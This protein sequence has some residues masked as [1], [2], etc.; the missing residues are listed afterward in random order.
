MGADAEA[1][2][3]PA[4]APAAT[5][6]LLREGPGGLE[7]YL[8]RRSRGSGFMAGNWVFPGGMV[9]AGD[10]RAELVRRA[11]DLAPEELALR[12]GDGLEASEAGAYAVAAVREA[13]EE[14]GALFLEAAGAA[15]EE[16]ARLC[17][18]RRAGRLERGWLAGLLAAGGWVLRLSALHAWSHWITPLGM[19]KRFDTRFFAALL[20]AGQACAPDGREVTEGRWLTAAEA[21][22]RNAAG[23]LPL[24]PPAV[25]TLHGMLGMENTAAFRRA[26]AGRRWGEPIFPRL[27]P[28]EKPH[29]AMILEPWDPEYGAPRVTADPAVLEKGLAPIGAPFSR[30]WNADGVW[31]PV[32]IG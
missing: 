14:A 22:R 3:P 28:L 10:R 31:R 30:L 24:S 8:L 16:G 18:L 12:W 4:A 32:A 29:G 1:G 23:T 13:F 17:G 7:T 11:A 21:L 20:P 25:V 9:D 6:I 27:V 26:A 5:L 15:E 19:P 2:R